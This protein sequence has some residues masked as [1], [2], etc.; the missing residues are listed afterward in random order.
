MAPSIG[1]ICSDSKGRPTKYID[2]LELLCNELGID[3]ET[4]LHHFVHE[5]ETHHKEALVLRRPGDCN[6]AI[7]F[8]KT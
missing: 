8:C 6:N 3:K 1:F 7:S 2:Q 5:L 4:K